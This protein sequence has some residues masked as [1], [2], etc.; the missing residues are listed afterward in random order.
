M[1]VPKTEQDILL[2]IATGY[3][4]ETASFDAKSAL[5]SKGKSKD[6][7]VDV[8][9]MSADGGTLLY[10]VAEDENELGRGERAP[11]P[12]VRLGPVRRSTPRVG[13]VEPEATA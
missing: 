8:A 13:R 11:P 6:L 4:V 1:W 3:L 9:T 2:A 7:A 12:L 5:P 10:G